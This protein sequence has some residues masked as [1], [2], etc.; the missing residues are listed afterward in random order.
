MSLRKII[1]GGFAGVMSLT[2]LTT[3]SNA[4]GSDTQALEQRMSSLEQSLKD[5]HAA[6]REQGVDIAQKM[7]AVDEIRNDWNG[8]QGTVDAMAQQQ[9]ILLDQ[10]RKYIDEFDGRLK[11]LEKR[12]STNTTSG[13]TGANVAEDSTGSLSLYED[14]LAMIRT[15]NYPEAI[16]QFKSFLTTA[17]KGDLAENALF[18]VAECHYAMGQYQEAIDTYQNVVTTY[19]QGSRKIA[20]LYRQAQAYSDVGMREQAINGFH[21]VVAQAPKSKEAQNSKNLLQALEKNNAT[22]ERLAR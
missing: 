21:Q 15:R 8:F 14:A 4:A 13:E 20:A 19:P 17:P 7:A 18:W 6:W 22:A 11:A 9:Q 10:L 12:Y 1:L 16:G 2:L 5:L 3:T